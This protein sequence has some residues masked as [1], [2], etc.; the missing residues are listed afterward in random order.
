MDVITFEPFWNLI[1]K[2]NCVYRSQRNSKTG[3][4]D[5]DNQYQI[6]L[7]IK[8]VENKN[9][10]KNLT[11]KLKLC[12]DHLLVQKEVLGGW[13]SHSSACKYECQ[14]LQDEKRYTWYSSYRTS[15]D[16]YSQS[17]SHTHRRENPL[18]AM[19]FESLLFS[20]FVDLVCWYTS[21]KRIC[22]LFPAYLSTLSVFTVRLPC[23]HTGYFSQTS[24]L[25]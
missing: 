4:L 7:Q 15:V 3:D 23:W 14:T 25:D 1:S 19:W 12:I 9:C 13:K 6:G 2:F 24:V 11:L 8:V 10:S 20:S 18:T 17:V 22:N 16:K 5:L 21:V